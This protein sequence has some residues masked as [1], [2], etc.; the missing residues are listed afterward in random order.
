M[1]YTAFHITEH[2]VVACLPLSQELSYRTQVINV[3]RINK[4]IGVVMTAEEMATRLTRMCLDSEVT[5]EGKS[6]KVQIPPTRADIL[7]VCWNV[8]VV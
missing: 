4:Q 1:R 7:F 6:L 2:D 8:A 3:E 5:D